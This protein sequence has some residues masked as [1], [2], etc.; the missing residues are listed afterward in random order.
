MRAHSAT[1][2]SQATME[3]RET[4]STTQS[5]RLGKVAPLLQYECADFFPC[6]RGTTDAL[7]PLNNF[8]SLNWQRLMSFSMR[9]SP[10]QRTFQKP[11]AAWPTPMRSIRDCQSRRARY[12]LP[13]W[14][15]QLQEFGESLGRDQSNHQEK[16]L[17]DWHGDT[18]RISWRSPTVAA[19]LQA[20]AHVH[21]HRRSHRT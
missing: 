11:D 6:A 1:R 21:A 4:N 3:F 7:H 15:A 5:I 2:P 12:W 13:P 20:L 16:L 8:G 19:N 17:C 10:N 18:H 14:S 9:D